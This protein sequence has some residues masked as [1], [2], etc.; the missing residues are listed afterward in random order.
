MIQA[1][2]LLDDFAFGGVTRAITVFGHDSLT[3]FGRSKVEVVGDE[4]LAKR[5]DAHLIVTH[6]PPSWSRLPFLASLRARNPK[7]RIV[8]VEHTYTKGFM[9]ERV[10][11]PR[12]FQM[13]LRLAYALYDEVICVSRAQRTWLA[14]TMGIPGTKLRVIHPWCGRETLSLI[15]D[16]APLHNRPL[17]LLAYGRFAEEKGFVPLIEAVSY[18][19]A[20]EVELQL[21]GSGPALDEMR[22]AAE[23]H[24]NIHFRGRI[25]DPAAFL[26][27]CDA[28]IVPSR[29]EAFGLVA[30]EA[31]M[32]GRPILVADVDGLPEQVGAAGLARSMRTP[33]E[34]A[35][36]ID[37]LIESSLCE[38]GQA[39]R[40]EVAG[41]KNQILGSWQSLYSRAKSHRRDANTRFDVRELPNR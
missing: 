14:D 36:A 28:V 31:R 40:R 2:H 13:L 7:A 23:G 32:A 6:F 3:K 12:R 5:Y 8:H 41:L 1:I 21:V 37:A 11:S 4:M 35:G 27:D 22:K 9:Q 26:G 39:G 19:N 29:Y 30:T 24:A 10:G 16:L 25:D 17:R 20:D 34:I 33:L 15:P 38:M 18:F